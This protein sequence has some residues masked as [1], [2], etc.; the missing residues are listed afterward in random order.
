M[1]SN[2][3]LTVGSKVGRRGR[4][5]RGYD[6]VVE[7]QKLAIGG[8]GLDRIDIHRSTANSALSQRLSEIG[9]DHDAARAT[10]IS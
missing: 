10:L 5:V 2:M 6:N 8:Q 3:R 9:F 7:G 4:E 1:L